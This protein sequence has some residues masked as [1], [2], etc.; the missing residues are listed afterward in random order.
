MRKRLFLLISFEV[1]KLF[2]RAYGILFLLVV[3]LFSLLIVDGIIDYK[4]IKNSRVPFQ[5]LE[6]NKV[7]MHVHY[8]AYG[9]RG[10]RFLF[11]PHPMSIFFKAA[12]PGMVA[13]ADTGEELKISNSFKGK[14]LFST[15]HDF[16]TFSGALFL[17]SSCLALFYGYDASNNKNYLIFLRAVLKSKYVEFFLLAARVILI[18][19]LFLFLLSCGLFVAFFYGIN[20]V[21][22]TLFYF[23]MVL[24]LTITFFL[25]MGAVIGKRWSSFVL[26]GF[27]FATVF[28]APWMVQKYIY[29]ESRNL[30]TI[31]E[32]EYQT[33]KLINDFDRAFY[34]KFGVWKS[35]N[36]APLE[37]RKIINESKVTVYKIMLESEKK[38]I[39]EL[40][41]KVLNLQS[42]SATIPSAFYRVVSHELSSKSL[43]NMIQ[44]YR[45]TYEKKLEFIN[46]YL[47][48]KFFQPLSGHV[49][50]FIIGD[51]G[52]FFAETMIPKSYKFGVLFNLLWIIFLLAY[53]L[54][55]VIVEHNPKALTHDIED[56]LTPMK[57]AS[58]NIINII[59]SDENILRRFLLRCAFEGVPCSFVPSLETLPNKVKIKDI[60]QLFAIH[61]SALDGIKDTHCGSLSDDKKSQIILEI[62]KAL[63]AEPLILQDYTSRLSDDGIEHYKRA[64]TE[65]KKGR[66]IFYFS[67]S[68]AVIKDVSIRLD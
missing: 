55:S 42:L 23:A 14:E 19:I 35:G 27:Y 7:S 28:I 43:L 61:P 25:I 9:A 5:E 4:I 31:Y 11:M 68:M 17:I 47:E 48:K 65:L 37:I 46:F 33:F 32:F 1:K 41:E 64:I 12:L 56:Q 67:N 60:L 10:L 52:I 21:S 26:F 3:L 13:E 6:K 36:I 40:E 16:M 15:D 50:S 30:D 24:I 58:D 54:Y 57:Y 29:L 8:T 63:P 51:D 66:K 18:N 34:K 22:I 62:I 20:L 2:T 44:F 49:E 59:T 45:Y 53:Y 39:S 38:R